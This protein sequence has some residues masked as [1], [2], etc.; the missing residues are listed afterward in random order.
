M[1]HSHDLVLKAQVDHG[2]PQ[3]YVT[4]N[5]KRKVVYFSHCPLHGS[6]VKEEW[7][8]A[9]SSEW[10]GV[11]LNAAGEER[12]G[13]VC[14]GAGGHMFHARPDPTAPKTA[15]QVSKWMEKQIAD[16]AAGKQDKGQH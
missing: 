13:F 5:D 15:A 7:K 8:G 12:W 1:T 14:K 6:E 3:G 9:R 4:L 16:R 10:R 11:Q 2:L